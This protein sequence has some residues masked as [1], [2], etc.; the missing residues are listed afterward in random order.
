MNKV[1]ITEQYILHFHDI[2]MLYIQYILEY[3]VLKLQK[4]VA[5]NRGFIIVITI[6]TINSLVLYIWKTTA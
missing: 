6:G 4:S 5:Y 1:L 2:R 3:Y